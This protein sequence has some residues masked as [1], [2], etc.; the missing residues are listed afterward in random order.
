[1]GVVDVSVDDRTKERREIASTAIAVLDSSWEI[2]TFEGFGARASLDRHGTVPG[3]RLQA[4]Q[5]IVGGFPESSAPKYMVHDRDGINGDAASASTRCSPHRDRPGRIPTLSGLSRWAA[6]VR[7]RQHRY[8]AATARITLAN[9][10]LLRRASTS[11]RPRA[12]LHRR[13]VPLRM[14][15]LPAQR[16]LLLRPSRR[17]GDRKRQSDSCANVFENQQS[18]GVRYASPAPMGVGP[19]MSLSP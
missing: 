17:R 5:Q 10:K 14:D 9:A 6:I 16:L 4:A 19:C 18:S 15:L 7:F 1:V 8:A 12:A 13:L 2:Q 11:A 3:D